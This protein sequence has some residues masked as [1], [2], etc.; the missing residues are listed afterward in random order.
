MFLTGPMLAYAVPA[1]LITMLPGPDTAMVLT[2]A[3]RAG[4][5][6]AARAAWGVGTGLLVWGVAAAVGLAP[7]LR[8]CSVAYLVFRWACGVYLLCLG[9]R[10]VLASRSHRAGA[11]PEPSH[12]ARGTALGWGYRR[13]LLTCVLNPK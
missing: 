9:A 13:A 2:T 1:A 6:A 10:A 7:A 3:L 8:S 11:P 5:G 12:Q 4:R